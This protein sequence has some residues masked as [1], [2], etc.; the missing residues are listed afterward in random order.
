MGEGA[1]FLGYAAAEIE[2]EWAGG[3]G[4]GRG[5]EEREEVWVHGVFGEVQGEEFEFADAGV[6]DEGPEGVALEGSADVVGERREEEGNGRD[7]AKYHFVDVR[8]DILGWEM[9]VFF[10]QLA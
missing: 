2:E 8:I 6:G 9:A 1:E 7:R 10:Q 3:L 4:L 5:M